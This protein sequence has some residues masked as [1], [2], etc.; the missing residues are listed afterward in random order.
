M[1]MHL[2]FT[3]LNFLLCNN[4]TNIMYS[5][6]NYAFVFQSCLLPIISFPPTIS[7]IYIYI[8]YKEACV[9]YLHACNN[10]YLYAGLVQSV[11]IVT[12]VWV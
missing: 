7:Y 11:V 8:Y 3:S 1:S 5:N 6:I 2:L 10:I 12:C 9:I 4:F